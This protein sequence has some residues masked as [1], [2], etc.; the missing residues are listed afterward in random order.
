[1]KFGAQLS[2]RWEKSESTAAPLPPDL[3]DMAA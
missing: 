1:M 2:A 3:P